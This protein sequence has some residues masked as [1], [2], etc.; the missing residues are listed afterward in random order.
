MKTQTKKAEPSRWPNFAGL[1]GA[2]MACFAF[3]LFFVGCAAERVDDGAQSLG[4]GT[5]AQLTDDARP[6]DHIGCLPDSV[7]LLDGE[8]PTAC[9][10]GEDWMLCKH[11]DLWSLDAVV[12]YTDPDASCR[13]TRTEVVEDVDPV[14]PSTWGLYHD[15]T[16]EQINQRR[17]WED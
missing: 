6:I 4:A 15:L 14:D 9:E 1:A 17:V 16:K 7:P 13:W 12:F 8:M 2:L 11:G 5:P 3:F 10:Y